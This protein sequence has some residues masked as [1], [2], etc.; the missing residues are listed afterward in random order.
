MMVKKKI[1][2]AIFLCSVLFAVVIPGLYISQEK[3]FYYWDYGGFQGV[4]IHQAEDVF[5]TP[6]IVLHRTIDSINLEYNYLY[7]IPLIPLIWAFGYSRLSYVLS[8]S[9]TYQIPFS[10]VAGAIGTLLIRHRRNLVFWSVV[11]LCLLTPIAWA[12]T[13]RGYPD[14]GGALFLALAVWVYCID[15][16]LGKWWQPV[17]MGSLFAA[18]ILF[19]RHFI[20]DVIAFFIAVGIQGVIPFVPPGNLCKPGKTSDQKDPVSKMLDQKNHGNTKYGTWSTLSQ[21]DDPPHMT[22]SD[23]VMRIGLAGLVCLIV[24]LLIGKPLL[25]NILTTDYGALFSSYTLPA[26]QILWFF[27][28]SYGW[29]TWILVGVGFSIGCYT[30]LLYR[31]VTLFITLFSCISLALW[32]LLARQAGIHYTLHSTLFVVLGLAAFS[33]TVYVS[34]KKEYRIIILSAFVLFIITNLYVGLVPVRLNPQMTPL[35]KQLFSTTHAPLTR[36]DYEEVIRLVAHLRSLSPEGGMIYVVD[37]SECMN[38]DLLIKAEEALYDDQRLNVAVTPQIDSRD[39]YPLELVM[40]AEYVILTEPLQRHLSNPEEQKV[41]EVVYKAFAEKWEIS[42]D[43]HRLPKQFSLKDRAVLSIYQR[44]HSTS[45]ETAIRTLAAMKSFIGRRPGKQPDWMVLSSP[46][47]SS[48]KNQRDGIMQVSFHQQPNEST[49][50][51]VNGVETGPVF[52]YADELEGQIKIQ[53]LA[54]CSDKV[55]RFLLNAPEYEI[56]VQVYNPLV[57]IFQ[58]R[59]EEMFLSTGEGSFSYDFY[60]QE[61]VYLIVSIHRFFQEEACELSIDW[62]LTR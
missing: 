8:I 10:L 32:I 60:L 20:Y 46:S 2:I 57:E 37:S 24:M 55:D 14:V 50:N 36:P 53:G 47:S 16:R 54:K 28:S 1:F 40:Q 39:F 49:L 59:R 34:L 19:R 52:L 15:T 5:K 48:I 62:S 43:F 26:V 25:V 44:I 51:K 17:A 3:F 35:G 58:E 61:P 41:V 11:L 22:L 27:L 30:N 29:V 12:P 13:L 42:Q 6:L 4:A 7:T 21:N 45:I 9:L 56:N 18:S 33:W 38:Y 23:S 31:P